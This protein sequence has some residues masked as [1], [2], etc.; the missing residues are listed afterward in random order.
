MSI[1]TEQAK[2]AA[3]II[4]R[5]PKGTSLVVGD[6]I[7]V[8]SA[9]FPYI[10]VRSSKE[11]PGMLSDAGKPEG[12]HFSREDKCDYLR[13]PVKKLSDGLHVAQTTREDGHKVEVKLTVTDGD[14][15]IER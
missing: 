11:F 3:E 2:T 6:Q 15:R 14:W 7:S 13:W 8:H 12:I 5:L 4:N 10:F 1:T 9:R